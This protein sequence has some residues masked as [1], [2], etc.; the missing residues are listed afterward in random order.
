ML[1]SLLCMAQILSRCKD[2]YWALFAYNVLEH[3][4]SQL[5]NLYCNGQKHHW[6]HQL[7]N[8]H[9]HTPLLH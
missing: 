6:R 2:S 9:F 1:W 7:I 5:C 8:Q 4:K 3:S